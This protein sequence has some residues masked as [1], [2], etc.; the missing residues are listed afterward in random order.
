MTQTIETK[1]VLDGSA[2]MRELA[3]LQAQEAR[4]GATSGAMADG[5]R[6]VDS[7]LRSYAAASTTATTATKA[8]DSALRAAFGSNDYERRLESIAAGLRKVDAGAARAGGSTMSAGQA[9]L[10]ASRAYEDFQYGIGG[11]INNIPSLVMA[12]GA[13][14]GLAGVVSVAAVAGVKLYGVWKDAQANADIFKSAVSSMGPTLTRLANEAIEPTRKAVKD[15]LVDLKNF[16]K[17]ANQITIDDAVGRLQK[18]EEQRARLERNVFTVRQR[19]DAAR[20]RGKGDLEAAEAVVAQV[21]RRLAEIPG[22]IEETRALIDQATRLTLEVDAKGVDKTRG[23]DAADAARDAAK[24]AREME[25]Q[26]EVDAF[27]LR[28]EA[29]KAQRDEARKAIEERRQLALDALK[30][31]YD[32]EDR[33]AREAARESERIAKEAER[34]KIRIAKEAAAERKRVARE[35]AQATAETAKLATGIVAGASQQLIA[36]LVSGQ[37]H[38]AERFGLAIMQQAGQALVSY[39]IQALGKGI[40]YAADPLTAPLAPSQFAAA[41][42]LTPAGVALGGVAAGIGANLGG[43]GGGG[44]EA[45]TSSGAGSG[46]S[47]PSTSSGGPST[48]EFNFYYGG[49]N[50][51]VAE[52]VARDVLDAERRNGRRGRRGRP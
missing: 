41:A 28:V 26:A 5:L 51:R 43:G 46:R 39:G 42:I 38:A 44:R 37:E 15:L 36:D 23:D 8:T 18:L 22:Q 10:E 4:L 16:G 11:V 2:A 34:E 20:F 19:A 27:R 12:L 31:R 21:E 33:L 13:G 7:A 35:E 3:A 32:E 47:S 25:A 9:A 50:G 1:Y 45:R 29:D 52:D 6:Q 14:A 48:K 24:K 49:P 40:L 30:A 17:D